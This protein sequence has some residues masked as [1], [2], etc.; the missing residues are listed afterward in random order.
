MKGYRAI[1]EKEIV[2][3]WRSYRIAVVCVLFGVFG[4]AI[5]VVVDFL[6]AISRLFG[7]VDPELVLDETGVPDVVDAL[8]RLLWQAGAIAAVLLA[9]GSI[10]TERA[11]G[12][13]AF[14]LVKP[15]TRGAFV[16]AKFVALA[17]ILGLATALTVT[18]TWLYTALLFE[19]RSVFDWAQLWFLAWLSALVYGAITLAASSTVRSPLAAA[20]IGFTA[21]AGLSLASTIVTLNPWLPTGLAELAQAIVLREVGPDLD[22]GRTIAVTVGVIVALVAFAWLRLRREDL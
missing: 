14:V 21:F 18:A 4:I 1:L 9:M 2:E 5:P 16:W 17:M 10:A 8:V 3:S 11:A 6:P 7:Q 22:P 13:L 19:R 15:V 20:A 12:T